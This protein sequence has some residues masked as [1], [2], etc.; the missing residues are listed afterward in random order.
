M[1][2]TLTAKNIAALT[3]LSFLSEGGKLTGLQAT[4]EVNYGERG[5]TE[6]IDL[7]P[8]LNTGQK[9]IAE[10][11]YQTIMGKLEDALIR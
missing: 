3:N 2:K 11:V 1:P 4:C 6:T 8:L 9:L 7:W 5:Q 10:Q